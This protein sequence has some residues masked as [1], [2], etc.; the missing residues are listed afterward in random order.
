MN[1]IKYLQEA[2]Y[3]HTGTPVVAFFGDSV[4]HG[5]FECIQDSPIGGACDF[6]AVYHNQLRVKCLETNPW[7]PVNIINAGVAGDNARMGLLRMEREVLAHH[8]DLCVVNFALNDVNESLESYTA[9]LGEIFDRL[10]D[11]GIPAILLT[12]NMMNTY[13]HPDTIPMYK[14]YAA[15]TAD[16]QNSGRMDTYVEAARTLAKERHIP[17]ADAYARWKALA[18]K[19]ED[20]TVLLANYIN[21][22]TRPMHALFVEALLE[23]LNQDIQVSL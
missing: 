4:T 17:V 12:P 19:G 10:R 13:V 16:Y 2:V 5:V 15:V 1:L 11:A 7:L 3:P 23:V 8:P 9:S 21:H 22:P 18:D 14:A 6:T 20:T